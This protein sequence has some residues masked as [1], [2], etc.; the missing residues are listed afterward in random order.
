MENMQWLAAYF[1]PTGTTKKV[2]L[3]IAEGSGAAVQ[4]IDLC[5]PAIPDIIAE[6]VVLLAAVPVYG[7][8]VPAVALERLSRLQGKGRV[9]VAVAVYGNREFDD[10]LL[11]LK[12]ALEHCGFQVAAAGAFIAEHSIVRSI[13][14]G[15][16]DERDLEIARQFGANIVKKLAVPGDIAA[17]QVP[18]NFPYKQFKG[19]PAQPQAG[20]ACAKCGICAKA[21]PV[22]AIPPENPQLTDKDRCIT[23]MRCVAI[24]PHQAR[25]LPAPVVAASTAMLKVKA[26]GHKQPIIFYNSMSSAGG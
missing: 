23:C 24:C 15:R 17:I 25:T 21:C 2:A 26:G 8:R 19:M 14:A 16:P 1:S 13:A 10:A 18:G 3:A 5:S 22:G 7:G 9:A 12:S 4:E 11:E 20:C 6:E